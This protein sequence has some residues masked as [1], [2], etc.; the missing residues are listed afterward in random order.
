MI[1]YMDGL[2]VT[3]M[4]LEYQLARPCLGRESSDNNYSDTGTVQ[5]WLHHSN[6]VSIIFRFQI[7][8]TFILLQLV[9]KCKIIIE[10][11]LEFV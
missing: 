1:S 5:Q 2:S 11:L 8:H 6:F 3:V 9:R 10:T 4:R 7:L